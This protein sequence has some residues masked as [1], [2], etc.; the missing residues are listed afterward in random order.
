MG[1]L[2]SETLAVLTTLILDVSGAIAILLGWFIFRK[3][4]GDKKNI[5]RQN[6]G[7]DRTEQ[8]FDESIDMKLHVE[9]LIDED[10]EQLRRRTMAADLI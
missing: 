6:N 8:L 4:R 2:D 1:V 10:T 3:L 9:D 5:K 7:L